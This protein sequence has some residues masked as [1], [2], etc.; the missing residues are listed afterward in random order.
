MRKRMYRKDCDTFVRSR[1]TYEITYF[2]SMYLTEELKKEKILILELKK[3][4]E[5]LYQITVPYSAKKK[6]KEKFPDAKIIN[7][8]GILPLLHHFLL[9][10][11]TPICFLISIFLF[12]F[13]STRLLRI[14]IIGGNQNFDTKITS[15]LNENGIHPYMTM[16]SKDR[17]KELKNSFFYENAEEMESLEFLANGN[18]LKIRY[19]L[20]KEEVHVEEKKGKMYA[21]KDAII[22]KIAVNSG[23][24]MVKEKQFVK[25][26]S[27]LVDD[28]FYYKDEAIFVGTSGKIYGYTFSSIK[29]ETENYSEEADTFT[30]LL[31][32]ARTMITN[33]FEEGDRIDKE[34][35]LHFVKNE[36]NAYL[37]VNYTLYENIV[38]F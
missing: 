2:D 38:K 30:Y 34:N 28:S 19:T 11:T 25:E 26:G 33:T 9:Q 16:P 36:T 6:I 32:C 31:D 4:K 21:K 29:V 15:Y 12:L 37:I 24:V 27:L 7:E 23:Y 18:V 20:K 1:V 17:L 8:K 22:D 13:L 3:E 5:F 14:D 35:I 10:K